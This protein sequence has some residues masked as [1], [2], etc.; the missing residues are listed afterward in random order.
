MSLPMSIITGSVRKPR[1]MPP[2]PSVSAIVWRTPYLLGI[3]KSIRNASR[4]P[5]WISLIA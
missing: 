2:M 5:T 1:E 4:P 3:S